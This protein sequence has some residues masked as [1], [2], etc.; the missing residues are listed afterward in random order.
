MLA[1]QKSSFDFNQTQKARLGAYAVITIVSAAIVLFVAT[2]AAEGGYS[3]AWAIIG[4]GVGGIGALF[5]ARGWLGQRG[6]LG[7]ARGVVGALVV[8]LIAAVIAGAIIVPVY[9]AFYAPIVLA[10]A[11][12]AEPALV[13]VWAVAMGAIHFLMIP[14]SSFDD[15][16]SSITD[17]DFDD[18]PSTRYAS[19]ELSSLTRVNL[20]HRD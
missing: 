10:T 6:A 11:F 20:Y 14:R 19:S 1:R 2:N 5:A 4:G 12:V 15:E 3:P 9:G 17:L 18:G 8:A 13:G 7:Y 16:F